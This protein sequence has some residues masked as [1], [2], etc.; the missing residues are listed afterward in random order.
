MNALAAKEVRLL[1]PAYVT[2]LLLAVVPVWFMPNDAVNTPAYY[3]I[4]PF[5]F[6]IMLLALSSFGREFWLKTFALALAQPLERWRI[7]WTKVALLAGA[8][9]SV[10]VLWCLSCAAAC[11]D[12]PSAHPIW[13]QT[14]TNGGT[15]T[16]L[17][18]VGGLW[19]TLLLRQ[20]AAAFW[21]AVLVPATLGMLVGLGGGSDAML[22]CV[23][24]LYAVGGFWLAYW[25]FFR[26][27]EVGWSGGTVALPWR[28]RADTSR[29]AIR[30]RR[31]LTALLWKEVQLQ[32]F[33]MAGMGGLFVLHLGVIA[34]RHAQRDAAGGLIHTAWDMF[35]LLWLFVPLLIGASSVA[36]ERKLGTME[37][38]LIAPVSRRLQF[39]V[40]LVF[41]LLVG[42]F[43]SAVLFWTAEGIAT[44]VG[45]RAD[46]YLLAFPVR[47]EA[48]GIL[49]LIT[50]IIALSAFYAST[51]TRNLLQ[52]LGAAIVTVLVVGVILYLVHFSVH[53]HLWWQGYLIYY[54]LCPT[55]PLTVLWLAWRNFKSVSETWRLWWRNL[56]VLVGALTFITVST[57]L[58]YNRAW[59]L[60]T[61]LEPAHGPARLAGMLPSDLRAAAGFG[62]SFMVL[63]PDGRAWSGNSLPK[64]THILLA[65]GEENGVREQT[66]IRIVASGSIP[67]PN[68]FLPGSNWMDV[69]RLRSE[70]VGIHSD[71]T[72]WVSE[73]PH[74]P[75]WVVKNGGIV[76]FSWEM[77]KLVR[78]GG[79][80][81]WQRVFDLNNT[82]Y[83]PAHCVLLLKSD[84]TLWYWGTNS[85][86]KTPWQGLTNFQP[87]SLVE[88]ADW[89]NVFT[90]DA[91][92][93]G[94][95]K[96]GTAWA[97]RGTNELSD[98]PWQREW[99]IETGLRAERAPQFD[100]MKSLATYGSFSVGLRED[101]TLWT[102]QTWNSYSNPTNVTGGTILQ[103]GKDS[104]WKAVA[105]GA[106]AMMVALKSDG[107][108]WMWHLENYWDYSNV[109]R[110]LETPP[111]R[112]G[113]HDNW[114][115][116][117][118]DG[119]VFSLAADGSLW[120]WNVPG[121][122][123]GS[124]PMLRTSRRPVK[125]AGI[126]GN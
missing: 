84:G 123:D 13:K 47:L 31:P 4:F 56:A 44:K 38:Q 103:V 101:G 1:L 33:A 40:K 76:D 7:W 5:G 2:A 57:A 61:P 14:I 12:L 81:N 90:V 23:L 20:V 25:L 36:E 122:S 58:V 108:L 112:L 41:V 52:A 45:A 17:A 104:E 60:I 88:G 124:Q 82:V 51:L 54:F 102:W 22:L 74:Y 77:S 99:K 110:T 8:L 91:F 89:A 24:G 107:T 126:F 116:V 39:T 87:H 80:T 86:G 70:V 93:Y 92:L 62:S 42:G 113:T 115:A 16:V 97:L 125:I 120:R 18:F 114:Q 63:L 119:Y 53:F 49:S 6:G 3:A 10:F 26:V 50:L 118:S 105:I 72:L 78:F 28:S 98:P 68:Q 73:T 71:G 75:R 35:G 46:I 94:V 64:P 65:F 106:D 85:F 67:D 48:L 83:D 121:D 69:V 37:S 96:D 100:H 79:E 29:P 55:L 111:V 30:S 19:T 59:E 95:K 9:G 11:V 117:V 32:Q 34:L 66:G 109:K 21:F 15:F 43:L 27:Q